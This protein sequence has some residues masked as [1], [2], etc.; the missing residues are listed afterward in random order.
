MK[1][2]FLNKGFDKAMKAMMSGMTLLLVLL[3]SYGSASA[4]SGSDA[5]FGT[6]YTFST[7]GAVMPVGGGAAPTM[8]GTSFLDKGDAI[9]FLRQTL[10]DLRTGRH[11][12]ATA[13]AEAGVKIS[14]YSQML[15]SLRGS[16]SVEAALASGWSSAVQANSYLN[17]SYQID[18][19]P[20]FEE[21]VQHLSN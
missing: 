8:L 12:T 6:H 10:D 2:I 17:P 16:D 3:F 5:S 15:T 7:T 13:E 9:T 21:A 19:K 11:A 18:V 20:V 1:K 14:M 4:Q